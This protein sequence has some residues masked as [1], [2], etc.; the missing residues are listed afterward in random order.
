MQERPMS[1]TIFGI[2]N[3]CFGLLG[4]VGLLFSSVLMSAKT[5]GGNPM[6]KQMF[7][8]PS[9]IAWMK[10]SIPLGGLCS[11]ALLTGGIGLLFLQN[12]ARLLSIAYGIVAILSGLIGGAVMLNVAMSMLAHGSQGASGLAMI[13]TLVSTFFGMVIGLV[14]PVLL[15]I[16]MTR[17]KVVAAFGPPPVA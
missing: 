4:V 1:V 5:A 13:I 9:Y 12:W 6:L 2:L 14:Y 11:I 17:R 15:I 7:E 8:N 16:F 3:I 10:I